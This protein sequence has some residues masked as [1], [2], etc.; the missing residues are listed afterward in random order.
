MPQFDM[1][2]RSDGAGAI[3]MGAGKQ[4]AMNPNGPGKPKSKP[5]PV[6]SAKKAASNPEKLAYY[7]LRAKERG[8]TGK[9]AS[10][11]AYTAMKRNKKRE[12]RK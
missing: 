3:S 11:Y 7:L 4:A 10:N 2:G 9:A 6:A 5:K 12:M 1:G 8:K